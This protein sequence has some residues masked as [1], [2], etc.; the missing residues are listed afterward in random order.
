MR[1]SKGLFIA[2]AVGLAAFEAGAEKRSQ[3]SV[4]GSA[5]EVVDG[6]GRCL[7]AAAGD[8]AG[9]EL[10]AR[11]FRPLRASSGDM[12]GF[13]G[14]LASFSHTSLSLGDVS[15]SS[16]RVSGTPR[17][18]CHVRRPTGVVAWFAA[19]GARGV[20]FS[21]FASGGFSFCDSGPATAVRSGSLSSALDCGGSNWKA[22]NLLRVEFDRGTGG[23]GA[24][25]A[26]LG[27]LFDRCHCWR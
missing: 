5:C 18:S 22:C 9:D 26:A 19:L 21:D 15:S 25:V 1:E 23:F 27:L 7:A 11:R 17:R 2:E 14:T 13:D 3:S 6:L 20:A 24:A 12:A 4:A 16:R 8:D 10:L